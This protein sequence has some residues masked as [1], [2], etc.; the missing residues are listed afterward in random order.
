MTEMFAY[1][2][3]KNIGITKF[4]S[5]NHEPEQELDPTRQ[6]LLEFIEMIKDF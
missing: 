1:N 3:T 4:C 6:K 5:F 2:S